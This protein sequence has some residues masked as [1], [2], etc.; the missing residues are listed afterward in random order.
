MGGLTAQERASLWSFVAD[1]LR[2]RGYRSID[3]LPVE[4]FMPILEAVAG[5]DEAIEE[6]EHDETD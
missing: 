2:A 4:R 6:V 1:A 3:L 5:L